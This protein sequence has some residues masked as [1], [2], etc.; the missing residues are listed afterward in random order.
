MYCSSQCIYLATAHFLAAGF[1]SGSLFL[2]EEQW[3]TNQ[4]HLLDSKIKW[5]YKHVDV[6]RCM[7]NPGH[8]DLSVSVYDGWR[9]VLS[10]SLSR[11]LLLLPQEV[12]ASRWEVMELCG[13]VGGDMTSC[14]ALM[15]ANIWRLLATS[16]QGLLAP[17]HEVPWGTHTRGRTRAPETGSRS[18]RGCLHGIAFSVRRKTR[19]RRRRS[20]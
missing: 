20:E 2:L 11:C 7:V 17:G 3:G 19:K 16:L 10:L 13:S 18:T 9:P 6:S 4:M 14:Q 1:K 12:S 5:E 15:H 8:G